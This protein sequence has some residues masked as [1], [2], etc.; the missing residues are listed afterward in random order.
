M[1]NNLKFITLTNDG[2]LELT[3]N[4]ILSLDKLQIKDNIECYC[5]GENCSKKLSNLV[6]V[7]KLDVDK[8]YHNMKIFK[9]IHWDYITYIKLVIIYANLLEN[10]YVCLTD[11]DIVFENK[12]FLKYCKERIDNY[13]IIIQND[14]LQD[15]NYS[16][17]CSGFMFIKSNSNTLK[18]FNPKNISFK[19]FKNDQEYI[20][21]I[22]NNLNYFVLPL[23]LFP[24]GSYFYKF[25]K[26]LSPYLIHFNWILG[27]QK[28]DKMIE[29]NKWYLKEKKKNKCF[30]L[31]Y[32][33]TLIETEEGKRRWNKISQHSFFKDY[34]NKFL[35]TYGKKRKKN[36]YDN[37]IVNLIWDYGVWKN[38]E[39]NMIKMTD[40]EIGVSISHY[41]LWLKLINSQDC[42]SMLILEDDAC[43]TIINFEFL[44]NKIYEN[45]PQDWDIILLGFWLHRGSKKD[46]KINDF[47]YKVHDFVLL[48][49]YLISRKGAKKLLNLLP[50]N[51]P[52]DSFISN[53]SDK[54]NIYR[55]NYVKNNHSYL[56][57][58]NFETGQIVHTNNL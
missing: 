25:N 3:L 54:L 7:K 6:K 12:N 23:N 11:G 48:H 58:Q 9:N 33:I 36:I 26:N 2:Y 37:K 39:S 47:I 46:K 1:K 14:S 17:L 57:S 49:S 34:I 38:M 35:G 22:I 55:H 42:N 15:N 8:K 53:N 28:K 4:C 24:N 18:Y 43:K 13:D 41:K 51:M 44:L 19:S 32:C 5:I 10:K 45:V 21:S 40:S 29:Y 16:K 50:I 20:N 56:I 31:C 30:D 27:N 52:I